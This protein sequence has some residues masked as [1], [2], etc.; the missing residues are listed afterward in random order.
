MKNVL[1]RKEVPE[2][3]VDTVNGMTWNLRDQQP[4]NF[5]LVVFYRGLHCP[6]C[7]SYLEELN[8]KIERFRDKGVNVI[9]ISSNTGSLAEKTAT[10]WDIEKLTIGFDFSI[11]N[12]RKWDLYI[13]EGI[14]EKE[15][16]RFFEP[17]LFLIKPDNTLYAASIQ[18]MPFARPKFDELL[19]SITFILNEK[20]PARGEA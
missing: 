20:Y 10:K 16:E 7:K 12:A 15:P 18:S 9:C 14:N 19:K 8:S 13:S 1:P 2:L 11:E 3:L 17:G 4:K 5:T 6:V